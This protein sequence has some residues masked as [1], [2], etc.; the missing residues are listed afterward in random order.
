MPLFPKSLF[1]KSIPPLKT[2]AISSAL[3]L[4]ILFICLS[5]YNVG[6]YSAKISYYYLL[7]KFYIAIGIK[8]FDIDIVGSFGAVFT[9]K[10][11]DIV[12]NFY[13]IEIYRK[14]IGSIIS[15]FVT[16]L[17]LTIVL[18]AIMASIFIASQLRR[19]LDGNIFG[20]RLIKNLFSKINSS[21]KNP[22]LDIQTQ[23]IQIQ[24]QN[25]PTSAKQSNALVVKSKT[26]SKTYQL[27]LDENLPYPMLKR[28]VVVD[29]EYSGQL[30]KKEKK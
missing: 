9:R 7:A 15:S 2:I 22:I 19:N 20:N 6:I 12:D 11:T 3:V 21:N 4:V 5:C 26:K 24:G 14:A 10:A 23:D 8:D 29:S 28:V 27:I 18:V 25:K 30:F 13:V 16:S 1:P 17:I